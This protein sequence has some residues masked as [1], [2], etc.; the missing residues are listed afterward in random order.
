M[1]RID[2]VR[3]YVQLY[4]KNYI[5]FVSAAS[6]REREMIASTKRRRTLMTFRKNRI[7]YCEIKS[8]SLPSISQYPLEQK[9]SSMVRCILICTEIN[10]FVIQ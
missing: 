8:S 7:E 10:F 4:T 5:F 6:A 2:S 3:N 9:I 1:L